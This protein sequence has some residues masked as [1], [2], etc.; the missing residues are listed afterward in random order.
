MNSGRWLQGIGCGALL[1]VVAA[2][3]GVAQIAVKHPVGARHGFLTVRT[4][5]GVAMG[6]AELSEYAVGDVVTVDMAYHFLDGS[7]DEEV[8]SF[9]QGKTFEFLSDH[10]VQKGKFFKT[11]SD[12][13]VEANGKATVKSIGKDG[14]EKVDTAQMQ[15]TP[16][17]ANGMVGTVMENI[18]ASA[19]EFKLAMIAPTPK[20]LAIKLDITPEGEQTFRIAGTSRKA[21][22]FRVRPQIG[23]VI[24][25]VA[26]M[27]NKQPADITISVL[28]G[29]VPTIVRIQQQ[30]AEGT[31]ML[32]IEMAGASFP[33]VTPPA[34]K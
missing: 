33:R 23:G 34:K 30:L 8:S 21:H 1:A 24:G 31:P 20:P 17:L 7:L 5:S 14:K 32:D 12:M 11:Q 4:Q 15:I 26:A 10:H 6:Y 13:L 28:E 29:E 9:R 22:V 25:V 18:P 27:I 2:G 3:H 16:D 19:G